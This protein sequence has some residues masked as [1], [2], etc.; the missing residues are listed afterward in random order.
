MLQRYRSVLEAV[1]IIVIAGLVGV[2]V[3]FSSRISGARE[4]NAPLVVN[5]V[6]PAFCQRDEAT[7]K[8]NC[9]AQDTWNSR[10]WFE[11]YNRTGAWQTLEG[12]TAE[13]VTGERLA[14]PRL[15]VPPYGYAIVAASEATFQ[16]EHPDFIGLT[17]Y[18]TQPW[19]G[20]NRQSGFLVLRNAKGDAVDSVN[21]GT[22]AN[23]PADV[24]FWKAPAF[25]SGAP[26]VTAADPKTSAVSI[27]ADNS[28]ERRPSGMDRDVPADFIRQPFPSPGTV[29]EPS[30]T[31]AAYAL[32]ID[33]TNVASLGGGLLLWIA[34]I[35]VALIARRFETLTQQ[36][37][38]WQ[39]ML[40]APSGILF[41][42]VVQSYGFAQRGSMLP[43]EQMWGFTVLFISALLCLGLVFLFR[44]R[45]K[46]ILEG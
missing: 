12:W 42:I 17:A 1:V 33:W 41:Y 8:W 30:A 21:W 23:G 6:Y 46:N 38:F 11:L 2:L 22:V 36:R 27:L 28:L 18:P 35:F 20:L 25:V 13:M 43:N 9:A 19:P 45:A 29:T 40:V 15:V 34:F 26:W 37:A 16:A 4:S 5:E 10:Q 7:R 39:A 31:A 32:F 3:F 14:I 24:K 44:Q